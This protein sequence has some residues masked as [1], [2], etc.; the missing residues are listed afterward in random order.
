M[1][2]IKFPVVNCCFADRWSWFLVSIHVGCLD[3]FI[4]K[5]LLCK[6]Q[7]PFMMISPVFRGFKFPK[8]TFSS[9]TRCLF[10]DKHFRKNKF[11]SLGQV[12]HKFL[13]VVWSV[14]FLFCFLM[15]P[16]LF[17]SD[18]AVIKERVLVHIYTCMYVYVLS[19]CTCMF[20]KNFILKCLFKYTHWKIYVIPRT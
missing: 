6:L 10:F 2:K 19:I 5:L 13:T 9:H 11:G 18:I 3:S 20:L 12:T 17:L 15:V 4:P 8:P 7:L 1:L 16:N 14:L